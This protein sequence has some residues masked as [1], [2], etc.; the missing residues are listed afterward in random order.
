MGWKDM[1]WIN[2]ARASEKWWVLVRR[3]MN[4]SGA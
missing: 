4:L 2:L 3:A 1:D